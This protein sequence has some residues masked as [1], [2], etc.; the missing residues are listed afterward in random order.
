[1]DKSFSVSHQYSDWCYWGG[2]WFEKEVSNSELDLGT[3][4]DYFR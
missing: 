2:C 3:H 1:M 4:W